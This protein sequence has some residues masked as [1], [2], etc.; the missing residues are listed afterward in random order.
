MKIPIIASLLISSFFTDSNQS[1]INLQS[2]TLEQEIRVTDDFGKANP[3]VIIRLKPNDTI[4]IT[5][6]DKTV[7]KGIV[8]EKQSINE[9]VIKIFGEITNKENT[10]FGFGLAR[11]GEFVGAIVFRDEEVTY[12][13]VQSKVDGEYYFLENKEP[14]IKEKI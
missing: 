4:R 9:E 14:K 8:K 12:T 6:Q 13:L 7:L 1:N 5:L 10:G 11:S 3:T 2:L